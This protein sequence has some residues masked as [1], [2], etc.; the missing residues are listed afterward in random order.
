MVDFRVMFFE[1]LDD[2]I[3][4]LV[5]LPESVDLFESSCNHTPNVPKRF[6]VLCKL[7]RKSEVRITK[8]SAICKRIYEL[9][10]TEPAHCCHTGTFGHCVHGGILLVGHTICGL[11]DDVLQV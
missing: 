9:Q 7:E 2:V 5:A 11:L 4:L 10:A 3:D 6:A 1:N 8:N